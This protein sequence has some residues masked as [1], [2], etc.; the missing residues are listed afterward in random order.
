MKKIPRAKFRKSVFARDQGVCAKCG[1]FDAKFEADHIVALWEGGKDALDN[2]Q[3]LCRHCH[4]Q[5]TVGEAPLRAKADRLRVRHD[6]TLRRRQ[7]VR[8][9]TP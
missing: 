3:T 8:E 4:L 5:K 9:Q 7:I 2:L 6:A 1:R